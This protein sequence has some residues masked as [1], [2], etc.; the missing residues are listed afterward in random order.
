MIDNGIGKKKLIMIIIIAVALIALG[1]ILSLFFLRK[2]KTASPEIS[3]LS[4]QPQI[5]TSSSEESVSGNRNKRYD[6]IAEVL[7]KKENELTV[8]AFIPTGPFSTIKELRTLKIN[9]ETEFIKVRT[10]DYIKSSFDEIRPGDTLMVSAFD[11]F[12][13]TKVITA[14]IVRIYSHLR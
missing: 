6:F 9:K 13:D 7:N 3:G 12:E 1:V 4:V 2:E 11:N 10:D 14:V 8:N 5:S